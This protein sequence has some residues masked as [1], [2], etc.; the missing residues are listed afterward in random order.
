MTGVKPILHASASKTAQIESG[1][2]SI[3]ALLSLTWVNWEN[4]P[5]CCA[6]SRLQKS[7]TS[8]AEGKRKKQLGLQ[9]YIRDSTSLKKQ[10]AFLGKAL[11]IEVLCLKDTHRN[12]FRNDLRTVGVYTYQ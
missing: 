2:S 9:T 7:P 4:N 1:K 10:D 11:A 3:C 5:V 6:T 12:G 8:A